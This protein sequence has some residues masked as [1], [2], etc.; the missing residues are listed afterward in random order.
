[1]DYDI[2]YKSPRLAGVRLLAAFAWVWLLVALPEV[3]N[4][5]GTF[6]LDLCLALIWL[7]LA[8][9]WFILP[10]VSPGGVRSGPWR[11]WWLAAGVA[12]AIGLVFGLTDMGL[13]ARLFL[14]EAEVAAYVT[15]VDPGT[16]EH[17]EP[18]ESVGLF[19]VDETEEYGGAVLLYTQG[20][21][22]DRYGVAYVPPGAGLPPGTRV[23]RHL[24]GN[25][26]HFKWKF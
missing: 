2:A 20:G 19:R 7:V 21:F 3:T 24:Y 18:P 14:C 23:E 26:Y 13:R 22:I 9:A 8:V 12:G 5:A 10:F 15:C 25:W 4:A 17:F 6:P 1:M 11:R 16:H